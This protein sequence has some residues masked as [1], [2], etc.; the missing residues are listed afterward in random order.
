VGNI[1]NDPSRNAFCFCGH[2]SLYHDFTN[3]IRGACNMCNCSLYESM[4][5]RITNETH[6]LRVV[7]RDEE[8]KLSFK[9][10]P[11]VRSTPNI[12]CLT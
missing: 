6:R 7:E 2:V 4:L 12:H 9:M 5:N 11:T 8:W 10:L 3:N 1:S